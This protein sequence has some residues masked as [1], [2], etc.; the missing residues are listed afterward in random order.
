MR[1]YVLKAACKPVGVRTDVGDYGERSKG[2]KTVVSAWID[3]DAAAIGYCVNG[4]NL[5]PGVRACVRA[6]VRVCKCV[7]VLRVVCCVFGVLCVFCVLWVVCC[8]YL[9]ECACVRA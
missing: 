7:R 4:T 1:S 8:V 5:G 6:C 9:C 2:Q 3:F